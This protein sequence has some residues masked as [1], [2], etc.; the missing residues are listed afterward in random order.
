MIVINAL[1]PV[2]FVI[3]LG[4][5]FKHNGFL[6][7]DFWAMAEKLS[8]FV[9]LPLLL[10]K[11]IA[12][13]HPAPFSETIPLALSL[14]FVYVLMTGAVF[15]SWKLFPKSAPLSPAGFASYAQGALRFNNFVGIPIVVSLFGA[16]GLSLYA[17]VLAVCIPV[18]NI[19]TVVIM[20][21]YCGDGRINWGKIFKNIALHPLILATLAGLLVQQTG[22][23]LGLL[24]KT[25]TLLAPASLPIGLLCVGA[26]IDLGHVKKSAT[27]L[28]FASAMK[29]VVFPVMM[30]VSC[31]LL[32]VPPL[33]SN[34]AL[35]FAGLP[36]ATSS[37][38]VAKQMGADADL[39]A[40]ITGTAT[41]AALLTLPVILFIITG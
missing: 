11:S 14:C 39:M 10:F 2:I 9:L 1:F 23:S 28:A 4:Y 16:Q 13:S 41:V 38:V 35:I 12:E 25:V 26:A 36:C 20:V 37:Y 21:H 3:G 34:V 17:I 30:G 5:F 15:L 24:M 6:H 31:W 18:S 33:P 32:K 40:S 8:Y 19:I 27:V 29:L 7:N 22:L